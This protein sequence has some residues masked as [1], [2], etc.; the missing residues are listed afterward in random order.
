M[1]KKLEDYYKKWKEVDFLI[2]RRTDDQ[3]EIYDKLMETN[4]GKFYL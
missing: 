2:K 3:N 1:E 4:L